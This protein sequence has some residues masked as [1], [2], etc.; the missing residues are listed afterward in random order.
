MTFNNVMNNIAAA[1]PNG[2]AW[3]YVIENH[4]IQIGLWDGY[5]FD[6]EPEIIPEH[7][8]ELRVFDKRRELRATPDGKGDFIVRDS[9]EYNDADVIDDKYIMYGE[10]VSYDDNT[11]CMYL[12]ESRGGCIR[13]PKRIDFPN[14]KVE[15]KVG[16]RQFWRYNKIPVLPTG[17]SDAL[18][19]LNPHGQGALE[20]YDFA[21]NGFYYA[22]DTLD[23]LDKEV[24]LP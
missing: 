5:A 23:T 20:I 13:F 11:G 18:A 16:V 1:F 19:G 10:K 3:S 7:M 17:E 21:F 8:Q 6:F 15:V 4:R 12:S 14:N 2:K 9:A 24:E 22:P